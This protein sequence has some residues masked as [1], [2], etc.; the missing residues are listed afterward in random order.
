M[1]PDLFK[2]KELEE[3]QLAYLE[4]YYADQPWLKLKIW[5]D[6]KVFEP[7]RSSTFRAGYAKGKKARK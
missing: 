1:F 7:T 5:R 2:D 3:W 6:D 4:V